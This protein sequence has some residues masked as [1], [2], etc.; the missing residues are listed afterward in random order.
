MP[1]LGAISENGPEMEPSSVDRKRQG[2]KCANDYLTETQMLEIL[3]LIGYLHKIDYIM[4]S[5]SE[6]EKYVRYHSSG[7]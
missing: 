7:G 1:L 3:T 2:K 6:K 5:K 4:K